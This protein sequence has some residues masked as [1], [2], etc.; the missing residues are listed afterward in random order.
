MDEVHFA[1][2]RGD[3]NPRYNRIVSQKNTN[4]NLFRSEVKKHNRNVRVLGMTA[5]PVIND[6]TECRSL[7]ELVTG[8]DYRKELS[9]NAS[10]RNAVAYYG[11]LQIMSVREMP[12]YHV[13]TDRQE[14]NVAANTEENV[15]ILI[16]NPV[17]LEQILTEAR[18]PEII[19]RISKDSKTIIYTEYVDQ[20]LERLREEVRKAGFTLYRIHRII[21]RV[22]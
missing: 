18:I 10:I 22:R 16:R 4:L 9:T 11:K 17:K 15:L 7:I 6:L 2:K 1:K 12:N 19:K 14:V 21:Q 8:K 3:D 5:T 13:N 20:I